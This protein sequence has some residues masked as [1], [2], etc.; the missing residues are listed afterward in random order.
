MPKYIKDKN[1]K[2]AGSIGDGKNRT[3]IPSPNTPHPSFPVTNT[4]RDLDVSIKQSLAA[5]QL[6]DSFH[7]N[8]PHPE[9]KDSPDVLATQMVITDHCVRLDTIAERARAAG[10]SHQENAATTLHK[11]LIHVLTTHNKDNALLTDP[12][13]IAQQHP[14]IPPE[15]R[16]RICRQ[17]CAQPLPI[18]GF[19]SVMNHLSSGAVIKDFLPQSSDDVEDAAVF[20]SLTPSYW[21]S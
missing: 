3:P 19:T 8:N 21:K 5:V 1:G 7:R 12:E 2:F 13:H 11:I 15:Q 16:A 10:H 9:G 20:A 14:G 17:S 4:Q 6:L 18:S